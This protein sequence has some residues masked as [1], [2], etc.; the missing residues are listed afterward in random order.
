LTEADMEPWLVRDASRD[1]AAGP[2]VDSDPL[3]E[4]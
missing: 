1:W 4:P 2:P 3:F